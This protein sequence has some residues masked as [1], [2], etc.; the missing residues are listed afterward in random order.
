MTAVYRVVG[1][2]GRS[3]RCL[4]SGRSGPGPDGPVLFRAWWLGI[5]GD[6]PLIGPDGDEPRSGEAAQSQLPPLIL[7]SG[8][9]NSGVWNQLEIYV[10]GQQTKNPSTV[11][12]RQDEIAA[13]AGRIDTGDASAAEPCALERP[14]AGHGQVSWLRSNR[15]ASPKSGRPTGAATVLWNIPG[16]TPTTSGPPHTGN[17]SNQPVLA[18]ESA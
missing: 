18:Q 8:P 16:L 14:P 3:G 17:P 7:V 5:P 1:A 4:R 12:R 6:R 9:R 10:S 2:A 11:S 15:R 13:E